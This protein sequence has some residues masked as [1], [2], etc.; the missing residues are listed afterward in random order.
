M[1]GGYL[2][3]LLQR[4]ANAVVRHIL[5]T[6]IGSTQDGNLSIRLWHVEHA[7]EELQHPCG[8][9]TRLFVVG[10]DLAHQ[11]DAVFGRGVSVDEYPLDIFVDLDSVFAVAVVGEERQLC[12][13]VVWLL[14]QNVI[15]D[16]DRFFLLSVDI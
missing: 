12:G 4:L 1:V 8:V 16:A 6:H 14:F 2:Q 9:T 10:D 11:S 15:I 5:Q 3:H 7:V 13:T